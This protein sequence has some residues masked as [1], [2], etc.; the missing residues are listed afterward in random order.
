M[1][2]CARRIMIRLGNP[3][4]RGFHQTDAL[5]FTSLHKGDRKELLRLPGEVAMHLQLRGI[6]VSFLST[7]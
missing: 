4:M 6:D 2:G 1:I 5:N 7:A 3:R